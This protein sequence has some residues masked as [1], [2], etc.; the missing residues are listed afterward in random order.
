M[1][2]KM[3]NRRN[4]L[5][6]LAGIPLG[7]MLPS[8]DAS[9]EGTR[10]SGSTGGWPMFQYNPANTGSV[11]DTEG[12]KQHGQ[13]LWSSELEAGLGTTPVVRDATVYTA[14]G[15]W[16]PDTG[17]EIQEDTYVYA[18]DAE[19]GEEQ[20]RYE[21][22][23]SIGHT[24]IATDALYF[25]DDEGTVYSLDWD[26]SV[27]WTHETETSPAQLTVDDHLYLVGA[28][29][30]GVAMAIDPDGPETRWETELSGQVNGVGVGPYLY[31]GSFDGTVRAIGK[32]NGAVQEDWNAETGDWITAPPTYY[33]ESVVV[34]SHDGYLYAFDAYDGTEQWKFDTGA[35]IDASVAVKDGTV[36]VGNHE[37]VLYAIDINDATPMKAC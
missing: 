17:D 24:P 6:L 23:A 2:K 21:A 11:P 25:A 28:K 29:D 19:T 4:T 33:A 30:E 31:C 37:A 32:E 20:W 26:K 36:F 7:K 18:F 13:E 27:H 14:S 5:T 35:A 22:E 10:S 16:D 12:P 3:L 9:S 8:T 34:G 15:R 1:T